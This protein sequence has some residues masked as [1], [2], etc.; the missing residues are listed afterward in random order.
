MSALWRGGSAPRPRVERVT[1]LAEVLESLPER[2]ATAFL[3]RVLY[4]ASPHLIAEK[5]KLGSP[6]SIS[7]PINASILLG[8]AAAALRQPAAQDVLSNYVSRDGQTLL[9]DERLRALI[10]RL[11]LEETFAPVCFQC[12]QR[13]L[14]TKALRPGP[15]PHARPGRP[16]QYC[17]GACRQKAYRERKR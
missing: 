2:E 14:P 11:R 10:R 7:G 4:G 1:G 9:I 16:R 8:R 15:V 6:Y 17:S 12:G 13:Y 5:L 3:A